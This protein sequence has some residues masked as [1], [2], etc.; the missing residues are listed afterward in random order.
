MDQLVGQ[1]W[2]YGSIEIEYLAIDQCEHARANT[3]FVS[4][5]AWKPVS[6]VTGAFVAESLTPKPRLHTFPDAVI[7]AK[8]KPGIPNCVITSEMSVGNSR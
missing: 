6:V 5:P 3:G 8:D 1:V 7:R 4:E 2:S